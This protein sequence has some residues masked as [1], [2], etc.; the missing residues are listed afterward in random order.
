MI[1]WTRDTDRVTRTFASP[2]VAAVWLLL[3]AACGPAKDVVMTVGSED[4]SAAQAQAF[5]DPNP[6][7]P[8][9]AGLQPLVDRE[10]LVLASPADPSTSPLKERLKAIRERALTE[11]YILRRYPKSLDCTEEQ[12][13]KDYQLDGEKRH[14]AH[15][16]C[17]DPASVAFVQAALE[18]GLPFEQAARKFSKDEGSRD[19]GGDIGWVRRGQTVPAFEEA[20]FALEAGKVST[21]VK[22]EYGTHFIILLEVARP[23]RE[24]FIRDRGNFEARWRGERLE[25]M[26]HMFLKTEKER[27]SIVRNEKPIQDD[28]VDLVERPGDAEAVVATLGNSGKITLADLKAY[29][30]QTFPSGQASH[31]LGPGTKKQFLEILIDRRLLVALAKD[32]GLEQTETFKAKYWNASHAFIA[33]AARASYLEAYVPTEAELRSYFEAHKDALAASPERRVSIIVGND[34]QSLAGVAK[35]V[36]DDPAQ[37]ENVARKRSIDPETA[38]RGGDLGWLDRSAMARLLPAEQAGNAFSAT[39]GSIL[40]PIQTP[41]G[42]ILLKVVA[43]R[44]GAPRTFEE[45]KTDCV[46]AYKRDK[47]DDIAGRWESSLAA[48]YPVRFYPGHLPKQP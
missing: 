32:A 45:A 39:M 46:Q 7:P 4:V 34:S 2:L 22:T 17:T 31:T 6:M 33:Q 15:I 12:L 9:A 38:A 20:A 21:P 40:G 23:S 14:L 24:D 13:F 44:E 28:P 1:M 5:F 41:F 19:K 30:R 42:T 48:R 18:R 35:T 47:R 37:F 8:A 11:A 36:R 27:T 43:E 10:R 3:L 25:A 16:L 29:M 26:K